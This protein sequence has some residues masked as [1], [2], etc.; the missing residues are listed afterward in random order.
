MRFLRPSIFLASVLQASQV[1]LAFHIEL[2]ARSEAALPNLLARAPNAT[3]GLDDN[4]GAYYINIT[5]GG[6]QFSVLIDTGSAD[7]WVAGTVPNAKSTGA[8]A[9][10]QY[11]VGTT[12]GPIQTAD[13]TVLGYTVPNQ[14]FIEVT[15]SSDSPDGIGIIGL[16]P[17][18]G[19]QVL[20]TLRNSSG[21]PPIDRIFRQDTSVPNFISV[22]LNRP[23]DTQATYTGEMTISE[24]LPL[25]QNVSSQPKVSVT[26]LQS[27]LNT[28]QHFSALLDSDGIIGPDGN[29]IK[30][31]SNA[32]LAPNHDSQQLQMLFD[33]GFSMPQLPEYVVNAIYSGAQGAKLVN[34]PNFNG[35]TWVVDCDAEL[36]VS[37]KLGGVT[38]PIH[39]LDVTRTQTDDSGNTYCYGTFQSVIAGA[40]D[41][42]FDG[43]LGMTFLTNVYL[44]LNYGDFIDGSPSNT[45]NPYVQILSTTNPAAAHADFVATRLGGSDTTGS[46]TF[47]GAGSGSGSGSN[48]SSGF[49]QKYRIPVFVVA[50]VGGIAAFLAAVYLVT[51][52]R[53]SAYRPLYDPAPAAM[54]MQHVTGYNAGYNTGAP[55]SDPWTH[56]R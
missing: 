20:G 22:L 6:R 10:I 35:E 14:A 8:S 26:V 40:Q 50:A 18:T 13:L 56:R 16:G 32:T 55:Y 36:N 15:P 51:R 37:F 31:T 11:A 44:V 38:Y 27:N 3:S 54:P 43:I 47:H 12:E 1:A 29:A 17:S 7:L 5:L 4:G 42:T 23:N 45:S 46:Q 33:T 21:D 39:P 34:I 30:L 28:S 9:K 2:P 52:R 24:V 25:F 19:S 48:K 53:K 41:P 49:F